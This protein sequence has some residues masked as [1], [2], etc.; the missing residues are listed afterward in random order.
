MTTTEIS[1]T[2]PQVLDRNV[3][4]NIDDFLQYIFHMRNDDVDLEFQELS[5]DQIDVETKDLINV[6]SK[7]SLDQ[8]SSISSC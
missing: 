6:S 4:K 3:F 2:S 5:Q 1:F 8:F 7:K